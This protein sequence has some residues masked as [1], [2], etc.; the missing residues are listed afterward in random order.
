MALIKTTKILFQLTQE[1]MP[2]VTKV[3]LDS[4]LEDEVNVCPAE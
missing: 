4:T 1:I 3:D 2:V